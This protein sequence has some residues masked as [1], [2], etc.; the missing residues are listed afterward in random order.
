MHPSSQIE[1]TV[2]NTESQEAVRSWCARFNCTEDML[3]DA[4]LEKGKSLHS[5]ERHLRGRCHEEP[6]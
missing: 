4:L 5:V 3:H 1:D 6:Y 2:I